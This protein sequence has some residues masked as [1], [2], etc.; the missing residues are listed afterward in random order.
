MGN[1]VALNEVLMTKCSI[2][3]RRCRAD[4]KMGR[5]YCGASDRISVN[6]HQLHYGE[7]PVI[8]GTSGS[9]TVF[10]A[11]C[12]MRC[13]FCQNHTLSFGGH[14]QEMD[15]EK[16]ATLML[17]LQ[18]R[19]AHNVN[20]VTPT[21][22]T[23]QLRTAIM[24]AKKAGLVIPVVWNSNAY[25]DPETLRTLEGLVDI[26]LPDFKYASPAMA[27]RYSDTPDY[28]V[29]AK[30]AIVEMFRQVGHLQ[31][32]DGGT[33]KKGILIRLLVLPGDVNGIEEVLSWIHDKLGKR[34]YLS[35]MGQYYPVH[36]ACEFPEIDRQITREEY[37][38]VLS[39]ANEH[40]FENGF[41]QEVGSTAEHTPK[42][43]K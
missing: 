19:G 38:F 34:T 13:V 40:G 23:P 6:I 3:P 28:P 18:E 21:Q 15:A 41:I 17:G 37:D 4:R 22:Y 31:I 1:L 16:V 20:F 2:C 43:K 10:F 26:Y 11:H 35:L 33:A 7:E 42:F 14:G 9:G 5:G 36:R 29:W 8:S 25:E 27:L 30:E 24:S 39:L 32:G 12:N